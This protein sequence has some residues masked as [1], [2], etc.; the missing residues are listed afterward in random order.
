MPNSPVVPKEPEG[1]DDY[2][3]VTYDKEQC[4]SDHYTAPVTPPAYTP[5]IPFAQNVASHCKHNHFHHGFEP[6]LVAASNLDSSALVSWSLKKFEVVVGKVCT[7]FLKYLARSAKF[8]CISISFEL[9]RISVIPQK[10]TRL[11]INWLAISCLVTGR[12]HWSVRK[13][14]SGMMVHSIFEVLVPDSKLSEYELSRPKSR[15]C[16]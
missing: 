12:P 2:T 11:R 14:I 13:K 16:K 3:E 5:S 10:R 15:K 1:S 6:V 4:L 8:F 7:A 9:V